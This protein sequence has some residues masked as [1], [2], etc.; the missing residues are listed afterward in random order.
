MQQAAR[1]DIF[2]VN[3][4]EVPARSHLAFWALTLGSIGVS[5]FQLPTD[6]LVE[7]GT[8]VAA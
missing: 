3:G 2:G 1:S 5:H 6:R 8:Q 4:A 7:I